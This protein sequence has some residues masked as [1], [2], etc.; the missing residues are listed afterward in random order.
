MDLIT[1]QANLDK[2]LAADNALTTGAAYSIDGLSLTRVDAPLITSKINYWQKVVNEHK[3]FDSGRPSGQ[4][5]AK[6]I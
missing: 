1:A 5:V 2:W 6:W 4:R 3:D